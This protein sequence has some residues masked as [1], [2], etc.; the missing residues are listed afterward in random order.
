[1]KYCVVLQKAFLYRFNLY[2]LTNQCLPHDSRGLYH[3][4]IVIYI[5][6]LD[7]HLFVSEV[8]VWWGWLN[9]HKKN[10][11]CRQILGCWLIFPLLY[12]NMCT[13]K[14]RYLGSLLYSNSHRRRHRACLIL[15]YENSFLLLKT[16]KKKLFE[17]GRKT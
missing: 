9:L 11:L 14:N 4:K 10:P 1:M 15:F 3:I 13:S 5:D 17:R 7:S 12:W 16:G 8:H 6:I 2:K